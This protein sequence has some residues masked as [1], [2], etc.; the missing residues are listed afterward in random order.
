[1][2]LEHDK[3]LPPTHI[4]GDP[5]DA[6]LPVR[7]VWNQT[8]RRSA[9]NGRM[10][11]RILADMI[12]NKD[13]YPLVPAQEFN[14]AILDST[15]EQAFTTLRQKVATH[16]EGFAAVKTREKDDIK[17]RRSRRTN[18]KKTVRYVVVL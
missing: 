9:H 6:D 2:D 16:A 1:M 8:S 3:E 5:L 17:A 14:R 4:E 15:F 7:F 13:L 10:K 18:R 11:S 12:A